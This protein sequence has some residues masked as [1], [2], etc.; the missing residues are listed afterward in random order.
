MFCN[1]FFERAPSLSETHLR[2][3]PFICVVT[4]NCHRIF[5]VFLQFLCKFRHHPLIPTCFICYYSEFPDFAVVRIIPCILSV[6]FRR[7]PCFSKK[8]P[9]FS[10]FNGFFHPSP[11]TNCFIFIQTHVIVPGYTGFI[12]GKARQQ[13]HRVLYIYFFMFFI[14]PLF[15]LQKEIGSSQTDD[16]ISFCNAV[17]SPWFSGSGLWSFRSSTT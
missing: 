16:P 13:A 17:Y 2:L 5:L 6:I 10:R 4:P 7:F 14:S 15:S 9:L 8:M 1:L 12:K 11:F 3:F